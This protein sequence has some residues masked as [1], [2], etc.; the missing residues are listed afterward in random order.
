MEKSPKENVNAVENDSPPSA[1]KPLNE[2]VPS[3]LTRDQ[4]AMALVNSFLPWS[5]GASLVPIPGVDMLALTALELRML[6]KLSEMY[7]VTFMENGVK[8]I[9]SSLIATV[10]STN[11]GAS[12]GSL[13]KLVPVVGS[14]ASLAAMPGMYSAAT[15]AIGRV[16]VT[17]FE[18]GGTFLDF[19]PKRN[20]AY[21]TSEFKKA[22]A[23]ELRK[24]A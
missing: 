13:M 21:F 24:A 19:D 23:S 20:R 10:V 18:A 22:A 8:N 17:H 14:L 7:G 12:L 9:V 16:F 15:Y 1:E 6:A 2:S 5:A 4:K 3:E 11:L